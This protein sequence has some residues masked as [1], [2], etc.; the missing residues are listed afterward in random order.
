MVSARGLREVGQ[1][2]SGDFAA[3]KRRTFPVPVAALYAAFGD[4]ERES[5]MGE[6][7]V[8]H[9]AT[10]NRSMRLTWPDG[11]VVAAWFTDKGPDRSSVSIPHGKL[12]SEARRQH[13]KDRWTEHF[14]ALVARSPS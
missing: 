7:T 1:L 13:E 2:S 11:T 4:P 14:D 5:W 8:V 6:R 3:T 10:E 9:T 12:D